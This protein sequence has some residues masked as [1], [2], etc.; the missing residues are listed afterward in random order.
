[1]AVPPIRPVRHSRWNEREGLSRQRATDGLAEELTPVAASRP[2]EHHQVTVICRCHLVPTAKAKDATVIDGGSAG[3]SWGPPS[4][5]RIGEDRLLAVDASERCKP[6]IAQRTVGDQHRFVEPVIDDFEAQYRDGIGSCFAGPLDTDDGHAVV[7]SSGSINPAPVRGKCRI[8]NGR[9]A[10]RQGIT[11]ADVRRLAISPGYRGGTR[12]SG[13]FVMG[14][15]AVEPNTTGEPGPYP[16]HCGCHKPPSVH[17]RP[18]LTTG[19]TVDLDGSPAHTT[20]PSMG[21][22]PAFGWQEM[23][24]NTAQ[25]RDGVTSSLSLAKKPPRGSNG[26]VPESMEYPYWS[27]Q[28]LVFALFAE[29]KT[30]GQGLCNPVTASP[31]AF[32]K[33]ALWVPDVNH[34]CPH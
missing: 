22:D 25:P 21:I 6:A 30:P 17:G 3:R 10:S 4:I 20:G 18:T 28:V 14:D 8:G 32:D 23:R 5:A 34:Q 26:V 7:Q 2:I 12:R 15:R 9:D 19:N 1:M 27:K 31:L 29:S 16:T 33:S 24:D 13:G 11:L